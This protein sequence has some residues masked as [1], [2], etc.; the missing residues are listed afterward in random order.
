MYRANRIFA[1]AIAL[2]VSVALTGAPLGAEDWLQWGGANRNF[3]A[4][5][6]GL[7]ALWP[8]GGPR[9]VWSRDLGEGYS[10]IVAEGD[11]LY[12]MYRAN[13]KE[14]VIALDA[15]TGKTMW[16]YTYDAPELSG[17][18]LEHGPGPH[19]TPLIVGDRLFAAGAMGKFT[20]LDKRSGMRLWAHDFY[21]EFGVNWGRGYSCSP[22]AYKDTVIMVLGKPNGKSV[23]AFNQADGQTAWHNQDFDYGPGSPILIRVAGSGAPAAGKSKG[24]STGKAAADDGEDQLIAFMSDDVAG[25][26]PSNGTLLWRH[27]HKTQWGLN[28]STPVWSEGNLLFVSSAYNGGSRMLK[29]TRSGGKTTV[30]ELWFTPRLRIH[31]GNAI[32]IGDRIYG[33]SGDFGPAFFAAINVKTGTVESQDRSFSRSNSVYADGKLIILDE[34]GN[35][36]LATPT[37]QGI[38]VHARAQ[39]LKS[40]AWTPP[41]LAGTRLYLRDRKTI[42]ALELG[43]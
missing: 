35:L 26:D 23:I 31:I 4:A 21:Q 5:S 19:A 30:E 28:I 34:D 13:K 16:E 32:R 10:A 14:T 43:G 24:K 2:V 12:T 18:N 29:L 3:T 37:P 36:A 11:R 39:V 42:R 41:T 38:Q 8:E 22:I 40:N 25:L 33:S 1:M 17:M 9:A 27:P 6:K 20:A 15:A 7:A